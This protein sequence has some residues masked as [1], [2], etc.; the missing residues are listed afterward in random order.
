MQHSLNDVKI[1]FSQSEGAIQPKL[2]DKKRKKT[3]KFKSL[4]IHAIENV[5]L[6]LL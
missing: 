5:R 3:R 6:N 4:F 2:N 1:F